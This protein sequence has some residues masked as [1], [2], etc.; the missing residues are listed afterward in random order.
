MFIFNEDCLWSF[1]WVIPF[2][3]V[4]CKGSRKG[5]RDTKSLKLLNLGQKLAF[6]GGKYS[7]PKLRSSHGTC[8]K[9]FTLKHMHISFHSNDMLFGLQNFINLKLWSCACLL[10]CIMAFHLNHTWH[11]VY[12]KPYVKCKDFP[13]NKIV[14]NINIISSILKS[15]YLLDIWLTLG[16]VS[17][18]SC[19]VRNNILENVDIDRE[20]FT[21][22]GKRITWRYA[23]P[24]LW[25]FDSLS[26]WLIV[27]I[28]ASV[29]R[30]WY[31]IIHSYIHSYCFLC[32]Q[33]CVMHGR[34]PTSHLSTLKHS[35]TEL[36]NTLEQ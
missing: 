31:R 36:S 10:G 34:A 25:L 16:N 32:H 18:M 15:A 14:I 7:F 29:A 4:S 3:D 21:C 1:R 11:N 12:H 26:I 22:F 35:F 6:H 30:L 13:S 19:L 2:M 8:R 5:Y 9:K 24:I 27:L 33:G 17:M 28:F 23:Q 20:V